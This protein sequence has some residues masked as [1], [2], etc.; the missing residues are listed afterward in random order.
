MDGVQNGKVN[1]GRMMEEMER[2]EKNRVQKRNGASS[3]CGIIMI[4]KGGVN[5]NLGH[6]QESHIGSFPRASD[7]LRSL[8]HLHGPNLVEN[9]KGST[10]PGLCLCSLTHNHTLELGC[11]VQML[12]LLL[13]VSTSLQLQDHNTS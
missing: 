12:G 9:L 6:Q 7:F 8:Y 1:D 13:R 5:V 11:G 4:T 2:T 3:H 10:F